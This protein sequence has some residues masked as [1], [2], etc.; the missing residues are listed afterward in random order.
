ME[1]RL[2]SNRSNTYSPPAKVKIEIPSRS[3]S[4]SDNDMPPTSSDSERREPLH[5]IRNRDSEFPNDD[6]IEL[7]GHYDPEWYTR[8]QV[9]LNPNL[10]DD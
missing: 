4:P 8:Q 1:N 2:F 9:S 3:P 10:Y 6:S 5:N 7:S